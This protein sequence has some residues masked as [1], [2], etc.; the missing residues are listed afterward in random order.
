MWQGGQLGGARRSSRSPS[1]VSAASQPPVRKTETL[2]RTANPSKTKTPSQPSVQRRSY[3]G[4]IGTPGSGAK[5]SS[6]P[7]TPRHSRTD[8]RQV[9]SG[10]SSAGPSRSSSPSLH[11]AAENR[12]RSA[13]YPAP[14]QYEMKI[15][16]ARTVSERSLL[17]SKPYP[18]LQPPSSSVQGR[19]QSQSSLVENHNQTKM[20]SFSS[21]SSLPGPR[22]QPN[23][24]NLQY[25]RSPTYPGSAAPPG[26]APSS[27]PA[28]VGKPVPRPT[29]PAGSR[30]RFQTPGKGFGFSAK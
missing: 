24:S 2:P 17:T 12:R 13:H 28:V 11:L 9:G 6:A 10:P 16:P 30:L 7:S 15:T 1:P 18:K 25:A 19:T 29:V 22:V 23:L 8:G 27:S 4:V 5:Y 3:G 20:Q 14:T 26:K 21:F